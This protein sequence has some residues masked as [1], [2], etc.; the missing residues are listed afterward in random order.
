MIT[1][2]FFEFQ[3]EIIADQTT[4]EDVDQMTRQLFAEIRNMDIEAVS[5]VKG[6]DAPSGTKSVD[7]VTIGALAIAVLPNV[8]PKVVEAIQAWALRG[9]GKTV[10]FKGK[11][12]GQMIEFE[13]SADELEKLINRLKKGEEIKMASKY[14]LIIANTEYSDPNL[15]QLSAPSKDAEDFARVLRDKDI[16][17]FDDV[18]V[19]L[20]HP[21]SY[22]RERIDEFFDLK[23]IDDLLLLYFSGHGVRDEMGSLYLA[24]RNTSRS[25]LRATALRSDFIRE[26]MD[27][28]R[29]KRIVLILDC[30]NSGAFAHG[31]K[32]ITGGSV[33]TA[34]A[35]EGTGYGRIV[36]TASDSTQFAWEGDRVIGE[37]QNSLFT[38]FLIKGLEGEADRDSDGRITVDELYDF[39]FEQIVTQSISQTPGKWSYQ[40]K[41][42]IV[43][44]DNIPAK[45]IKPVK[46][47]DELI[48]AIEDSRTYVRESAVRQ[49]EKFLNGKN[50]GLARSAREIL[51]KTAEED[52]SRNVAEL[53]KK[54]LAA[55]YQVEQTEQDVS[56]EDVGTKPEIYETQE[57]PKIQEEIF[58]RPEIK[59][60]DLP[61]YQ[62]PLTVVKLPLKSKSWF[63]V[64]MK[65]VFKPSQQSYT[66]ILSNPAISTVSVYFWLFI[67]GT[68]TSILSSLSQLL[69]QV[70]GWSMFGFELVKPITLNSTIAITSL[71]VSLVM[72]PIAGITTVIF[73]TVAVALYHWTA[74]IFKGNGAFATILYGLATL[75]IPT[76]IF[77]VFSMPLYA[78]PYVNV[79]VLIFSFIFSGYVI[80]LQVMM[81]KVANKFGWGQAIGTFLVPVF[82]SLFLSISILAFFWFFGDAIIQI[83]GL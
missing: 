2:E 57:E 51:E 61:V 4:E 48:E 28:S 31:T 8:L 78:I 75:T 43:L 63:R 74:R 35:F 17:G 34:S 15:S 41:G 16:A 77:S 29:S 50:L 12:H 52:D 69:Y 65:A 18:K 58:S 79:F 25:R 54:L 42:E 27:Q 3:V 72:S 64:S 7:P 44:R 10:K 70:T 82:I 46:L 62:A 24:L 83:L 47:P 56:K 60:M 13:G 23:K 9:Q 21:E 55:N 6:E 36:L 38:H 76:S 45:S 53:A 1:P 39:A 68:A 19:I 71:V 14:A 40:Q 80:Y 67:I 5:L 66:E 20:N 81:I 33:G 37:T 26:A 32:A 49:L 73:F 22:V 59:E 30:C 11:V